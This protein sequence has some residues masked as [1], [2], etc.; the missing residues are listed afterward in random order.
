VFQEPFVQLSVSQLMWGY[1]HPLVKLAK[2]VLPP[3]RRFPFDDFGFFVGVSS[4]P[5]PNPGAN[6]KTFEFT[7]LSLLINIVW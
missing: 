5:E 1:D 4:Q 7:F 3:E 2:D 6:P